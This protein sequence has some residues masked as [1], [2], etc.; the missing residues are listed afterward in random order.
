MATIIL[1]ERENSVF[2]QGKERVNYAELT[3][4][5]WGE[6][7][8]GAAF[9]SVDSRFILTDYPYDHKE[10]KLLRHLLSC[11]GFSYKAIANVDLQ[12]MGETIFA[13]SLINNNNNNKK[14]REHNY[15]TSDKR[16]T[17]FRRH[18]PQQ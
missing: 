18:F 1:A 14:K 4:Q 11:N 16:N 5:R 6:R 13:Q 10:V 7:Q 15:A 17:L 12:H 9:V 8:G 3:L 2:S